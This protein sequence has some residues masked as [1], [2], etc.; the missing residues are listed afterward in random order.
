MSRYQDQNEQTIFNARNIVLVII[1]L[2]LVLNRMGYEVPTDRSTSRNQRQKAGILEYVKKTPDEMLVN[3]T[4]SPSFIN[5]I[6]RKSRRNL[7]HLACI[8]S[9]PL[10]VA[11]LLS[12]GFKA[13]ARDKRGNT[14]LH[15]ALKNNSS[16]CVKLLLKHK[17]PLAKC[18]KSGRYPLHLAAKEGYTEVI[19]ASLRAGVH[20]DSR[21]NG[22]YTPLHFAAR[23]GNLEAAVLLCENGADPSAKMQYGWT[24]G[25]L[26]FSKNRDI[27]MYLQS[28]GGTMSKSQLMFEFNL[29]GGWPLPNSFA[30]KNSTSSQQPEL[31]QAVYEQNL[32]KI[33][34]FL[35][36][37]I[38]PDIKSKAQTPLLCYA[39]INKKFNSAFLLLE[40]V[41]DIN[42]TDGVGRHALI[43]AIIAENSQLAAALIKKNCDVNKKDLTGNTA[44]HYAVRKSQ[45]KLVP[46]LVTAGAEVFARNRF[47]EGPLHLAVQQNNMQIVSFLINNG[48]DVN[49]EDIRGNTA[50]HLAASNGFYEITSKLLKNGADPWHK[51]LAGKTPFMVTPLKNILIRNILEKRSEIEGANPAAKAP[52]EVDMTLPAVQPM[53]AEKVSP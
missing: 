19:K 23:G 6:E 32:T 27:S 49:I 43:L 37:G 25:D 13:G 24:P 3:K 20:V 31:F 33:K 15:L 1:F 29:Y 12:I 34:S 5:S 9:K 42:A 28:R 45:N 53:K 21:T 10:F 48:C 41:T 52:A 50:L 38:S 16:K 18:N 46:Q 30:I 39:I 2:I 22:G 36:S 40:K 11:K 14:P 26:A 4:N 7:L 17:A 51:N 44:L 47:D 35:G 8:A